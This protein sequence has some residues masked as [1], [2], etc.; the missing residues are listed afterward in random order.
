[1]FKH[2]RHIFWL[3]VRGDLMAF[4]GEPARKIAVPA[5]RSCSLN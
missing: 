1:M 4:R 2:C 5:M 3:A